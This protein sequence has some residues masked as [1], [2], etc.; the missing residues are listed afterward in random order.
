MSLR[1]RSNA[2]LKYLFSLL[3]LC[4]FSAVLL[5]GVSEAAGPS[6]GSGFPKL[7]QK[8]ALLQWDPVKGATEYKVY[9]GT[10]KDKGIK[11]LATVKVNHY[12]D[13]DL[14]SGITYYYYITSVS[15]GKEGERS[16]AGQVSTEKEKVFVPL[17]VPTLAAAH[18]KD[19]PGGAAIVGLR[20]EGTGGTDLVAVNV[21][22]S[23]TRGK[24]F[25]M[26]GSSA[27]D[28]YEDKDIKRGDTYYYVVTAVDSQFK[29]TKY[30]NE[31]SVIVPKL[32]E[33]EPA[34]A[35]VKS[36]PTEMRSAK[37]LFRI[38]EFK[39]VSPETGRVVTVPAAGIQDVVVDE[40][41]G[42]IY[43]TS[44]GYGGVLV[45][46]MNGKFQ[47]GIRKDGTSGKE[48]F[49]SPVG[50]GIGPEGDVYVAEYDSNIVL[51]FGFDGK[52]KAKIVMDPADIE[53]VVGSKVRPTIYDVAVDADGT[54]YATDPGNSSIHA[55]SPQGKHR[56]DIG[57][58]MPRKEKENFNGP[59][60]IVM[61]K[62]GN[63]V[64]VDAGNVRLMVY[65][66]AGKLVRTISKG[67][68]DAGQLDSPVGITVDKD[69]VIYVASA[70]SPNI[71]GFS[72][73]GEFRFA[74]CNEKCDGHVDVSDVRGIY[75][76]GKDRL[77]VAES[78]NNRL[79]VF[80]IERT[81]VKVL[82]K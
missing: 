47:F 65:D 34:A 41:V 26:L 18:V 40:A 62:S 35:A 25:I 36:P 75:I 67:G 3:T 14:P 32:A 53:R 56:L 7:S 49:S 12:L 70:L 76:D 71:Q 50:L 61:D 38:T 20:W 81:E 19:L 55:Y 15:G 5:S 8:N 72:A 31:I 6:W 54:V 66:K 39:D 33:A 37:L 69:G 9:R 52:P 24:D 78:L 27:S 17:K 59:T 77:Y 63:I 11:L 4:L 79:S 1:R 73:N 16:V 44:Y 46:D 74:L 57:Q 30:S 22:R 82:P 43:M 68:P 51:A 10:V 48:R 2:V 13:K 58:G 64:F 29:E 42:H 60:F 80:Q 28:M 23:K 45:Y 21:Y